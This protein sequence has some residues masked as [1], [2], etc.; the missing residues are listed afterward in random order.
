MRIAL[1]LI[2]VALSL[3]IAAN[4]DAADCGAPV[5]SNFEGDEKADLPSKPKLQACATVCV[6]NRTARTVD[7]RFKW[8]GR[9]DWKSRQLDPGRG[10]VFRW[11][12]GSGKKKS[13]KLLIEYDAQ[14]LTSGTQT[15]RQSLEK[16][17]STNPKCAGGKLYHFRGDSRI[18]LKEVN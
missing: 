6:R 14:P 11:N 12:Y 15:R 18:S 9:G 7:F 3:A 8:K 4:A 1:P 10:R 2:L 5:S 13:P 17:A 16:Y